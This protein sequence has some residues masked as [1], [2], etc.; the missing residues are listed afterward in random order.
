MTQAYNWDKYRANATKQPLSTSK[1]YEN[2]AVQQCLF[3][4]ALGKLNFRK[5]Y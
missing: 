3:H 2:I 1:L 4:L 5:F